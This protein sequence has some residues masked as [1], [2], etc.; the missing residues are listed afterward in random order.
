MPDDSKSTK[1]SY[2]LEVEIGPTLTEK[3]LRNAGNAFPPCFLA[4]NYAIM[5]LQFLSGT[6]DEMK[7]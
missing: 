3:L 4:R 6:A 1:I 5:Y 7:C 2:N